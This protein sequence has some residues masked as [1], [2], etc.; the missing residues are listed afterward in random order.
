[1]AP[2]RADGEQARSGVAGI[3]ELAGLRFDVPDVPRTAADASGYDDPRVES[4]PPAPAEP[5]DEF[6]ERPW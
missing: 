2:I 4:P 6:P 1:M 5:G 3:P